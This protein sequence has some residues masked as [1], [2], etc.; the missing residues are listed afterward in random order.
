MSTIYKDKNAAKKSN[1]FKKE[2]QKILKNSGE[3][4]MKYFVNEKERKATISK[5]DTALPWQT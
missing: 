3:N 5:D 1:I 4:I 2:Q